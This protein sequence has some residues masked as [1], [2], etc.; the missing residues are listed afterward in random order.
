[1]TFSSSSRT[2]F[3]I[4]YIIFLFFSYYFTLFALSINI[5]LWC[6]HLKLRQRVHTKW[7]YYTLEFLKRRTYV[8]HIQMHACILSIKIN[9]KVKHTLNGE[10]SLEYTLFISKMKVEYTRVEERI[11]IKLQLCA[12]KLDFCSEACVWNIW[13]ACRE[14]V[15]YTHSFVSIR[16]GG[17]YATRKQNGY[18]KH[19]KVPFHVPIAWKLNAQTIMLL[20]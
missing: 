16:I 11:V 10:A 5:S 3:F 14:S 18:P 2:V 13:L 20:Q 8:H 15:K 9:P 17:P 19:V 6:L 1:M 7:N 12:Q 4:K